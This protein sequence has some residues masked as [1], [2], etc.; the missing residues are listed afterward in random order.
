MRKNPK[1]LTE[2]RRCY[3]RPDESKKGFVQHKYIEITGCCR[4]LGIFLLLI[5]FKIL[6]FNTNYLFKTTSVLKTLQILT[7]SLCDDFFSHLKAKIRNV[8][9]F[10]CSNH[11]NKHRERTEQPTGL[12]WSQLL[13]KNFKKGESIVKVVVLWL[14]GIYLPPLEKLWSYPPSLHGF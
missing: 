10:L 9:L 3:F 7:R 5:Y 2:C 8:C 11:S 13:S 4:R 14:L 12:K 1:S 6:L